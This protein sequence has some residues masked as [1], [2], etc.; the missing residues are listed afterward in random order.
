VGP[1]LEE[2]PL[3]YRQTLWTTW[4]PWK[5]THEE[6]LGWRIGNLREDGCELSVTSNAA[7]PHEI[8]EQWRWGARTHCE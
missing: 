7:L 8:R 4:G 3:V 6:G 1:R 2:S 5:L